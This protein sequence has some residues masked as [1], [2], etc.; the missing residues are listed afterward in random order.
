MFKPKTL[1]M[2]SNND[3]PVDKNNHAINPLEWIV[4]RLPADPKNILY[5]VYNSLGEDLTRV[6]AQDRIL[7]QAL[8]DDPEEDDYSGEFSY[9]SYY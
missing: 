3:K 5:G 2:R 6:T 9:T 4:M 1:D 8:Q 7:P